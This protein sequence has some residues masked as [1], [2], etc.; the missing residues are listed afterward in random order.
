MAKPALPV[1]R[2]QR[3]VDGLDPEARSVAKTLSDATL[4]A[5]MFADGA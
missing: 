1:G 3:R 4:P 2:E 5:P